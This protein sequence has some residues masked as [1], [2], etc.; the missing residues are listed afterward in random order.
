MLPKLDGT[1]LPF[2]IWWLQNSII[3]T[4]ETE[5]SYRMQSCGFIIQLLLHT[6]TNKNMSK[7]VLS[8][9]TLTVRVKIKATISRI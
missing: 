9:I 2:A 7:C 3:A 6:L 1:M 4:P 5:Q 8:S